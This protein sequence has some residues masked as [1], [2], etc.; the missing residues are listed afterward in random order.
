MTSIFRRRSV[1][2]RSYAEECGIP[3]GHN[4]PFK[5]QRKHAYIWLVFR[6]ANMRL[7]A[8]ESWRQICSDMTTSGTSDESSDE[9]NSDKR[10][11]EDSDD[12]SDDSSDGTSNA[13]DPLEDLIAAPNSTTFQEKMTFYYLNIFFSES[14][15]F[16]NLSKAQPRRPAIR[17]DWARLVREFRVWLKRQ[18]QRQFQHWH[19]PEFYS[20]FFSKPN[21]SLQSQIV[22]Y[23]I[24][25]CNINPHETNLSLF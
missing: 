6:S 15:V 20:Y 19:K 25:G 24:I 18:T 8:I 21:W 5:R 13:S 4:L 9:E 3:A 11:S 23:S 1:L 10:S 7:G 14:L 16:V 17:T 12:S 22:Q 2:P